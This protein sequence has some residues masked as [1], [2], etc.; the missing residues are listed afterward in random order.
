MELP[1]RSR[2]NRTLSSFAGVVL[3]S[4]AGSVAAAV[5]AVPA[6]DSFHGRI[7]RATG[8]LS[9]DRATVAIALHVARSTD[10]TR[11]LQMTLTR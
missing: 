9:S 11:A 4:A 7:T 5:A 10:A 2:R 8:R 3:L 1:S 6:K